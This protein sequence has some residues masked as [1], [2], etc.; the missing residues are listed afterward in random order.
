MTKLNK[1]IIAILVM[2]F[3]SLVVEAL[4]IRE[5]LVTFQG[6]EL[7]IGVVFA[8]WLV[9]EAAGSWGLSRTFA[10]RKPTASFVFLSI[11]IALYFPFAIIVARNIR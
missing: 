4:A 9:L 7:I 5:L 1:S 2:G 3:N 8:T 6:N 11:F 10:N